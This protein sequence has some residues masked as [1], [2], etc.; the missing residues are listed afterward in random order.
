MPKL[1][2]Y[3]KKFSHSYSFGIYPTLE[4]IKNR[5]DDVLKVLVKEESTQ[6]EGVKEITN[7][8]EKK[9][10]HLE[11]NDRLIDKLAFKENTY[12]LGVFKKYV[13]ELDPDSSHILLDNP[14]NMGNLG[15]II[16]T[17]LGFGF[18]DLAFVGP[19]VDIFDPK[20]VRSTM[21]ALFSIR[22]EH[23][24]DINEYMSEFPKHN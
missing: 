16:R 15:T 7:L 2:K 4:L 24:E 6:T 13:S 8:C 11:I 22:F 10:I 9:G 1:K 23:Y 18:K 21:G 20:V 17:M 3:Q 12:A 5:G 14:S 19:S